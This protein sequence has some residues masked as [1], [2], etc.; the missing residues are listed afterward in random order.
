[1]SSAGITTPAHSPQPVASDAPTN[2]M[3]LNNILCATAPLV[4]DQTRE[5]APASEAPGAVDTAKMLHTPSPDRDASVDV[6]STLGDTAA[7]HAEDDTSND[8]NIPREFICMNDEYCECRTGQ[9]TLK[10]SRKVISNHFGRNKGCTRKITNWPLFC[11]K[12]YQRATYNSAL[13]QRRKVN[14][15]NR[16]FDVIEQELPGTTYTVALKKSEEDRLNAFCRAQSRGLSAEEAA[17]ADGVATKEGVSAFQAPI[18]VLHELGDYLG[19]NKAML[20]AKQVLSLINDM[21]RDESTKEV[22]AI[23]FLPEKPAN[24]AAKTNTS[25][26]APHLIPQVASAAASK[27]TKKNKSRRV[28]DKGAIRKHLWSGFA[29]LTHQPYAGHGFLA[30]SG[31]TAHCGMAYISLIFSIYSNAWIRPKHVVHVP[32]RPSGHCPTLR[33]S[34]TIPKTSSTAVP[35][36]PAQLALATTVSPRSDPLSRGPLPCSCAARAP[37]PATLTP[38]AA[39]SQV[40]GPPIPRYHISRLCR[41]T[42]RGFGNAAAGGAGAMLGRRTNQHAR[43]VVI[44]RFGKPVSRT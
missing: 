13:W 19:P 23:E 22:P 33:N 42:R 31:V 41:M 21:L 34:N 28:S 44:Y 37:N 39:R 32:T 29:L 14:L 20:H 16:Q 17:T 2:K 6:A 38:G 3:S 9:Y 5:S 26:I 40:S 30:A 10:L 35:R 8:A 24:N 15:I 11:R 25:D 27:K 43:L 1:M 12:H 4:D 36:R 18:A 7:S